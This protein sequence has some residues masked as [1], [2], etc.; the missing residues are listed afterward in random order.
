MMRNAAT[1]AAAHAKASRLALAALTG[2][3]AFA[4]V[5]TVAVVAERQQEL[6]DLIMQESLASH[7]AGR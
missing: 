5:I 2:L 3:S 4:F 1:I 7:G 6:A